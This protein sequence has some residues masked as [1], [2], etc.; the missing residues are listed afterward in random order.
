[1][2]SEKATLYPYAERQVLRD[3]LRIYACQLAVYICSILLSW[4]LGDGSVATL[5]ATQCH[6]TQNHAAFF[7]FFFLVIVLS[8]LVQT[9]AQLP[10]TCFVIWQWN[11]A[12]YY[13]RTII[14]MVPVGFT[15]AVWSFEH[16]YSTSCVWERHITTDRAINFIAL[17]L[18]LC[19]FSN[20]CHFLV[21]SA[22]EAYLLTLTFQLY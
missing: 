9:S 6:L 15:S 22:S 18:A 8:E 14:Y 4:L 19:N 21:T 16:V 17:H 7:F 12:N 13:L 2:G 3:N 1:M 11:W 5:L 10:H 20:P